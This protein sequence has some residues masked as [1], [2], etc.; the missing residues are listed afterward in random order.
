MIANPS[1]MIAQIEMELNSIH[2][3]DFDYSQIHKIN[4]RVISERDISKDRDLEHEL[5]GGIV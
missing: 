1:Y 4:I 5:V 3:V 2:N